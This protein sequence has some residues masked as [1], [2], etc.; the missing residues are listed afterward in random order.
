MPRRAAPEVALVEVG[1]RVD[2][3][4]NRRP[5]AVHQREERVRRGR[6]DD[7]EP[8]DV[9]QCAERPHQVAV[10]AA[11]GVA[12]TAEAVAVHRR[13][14]VVLRLGLGALELLL[15]ELDQ[16]VQVLG[17]ALLEQVVGQH[18]DQRRRQRHRHAE[19]NAIG[20]QPLE[21]LQQRQIGAGD[22][23]EEPA[24]LHDRRV[25]GVANEG[26]VRVK[27][28]REI[29]GRHQRRRSRYLAFYLSLEETAGIAGYALPSLGDV[30]GAGAGRSRGAGGAGRRARDQLLA[31]PTPPALAGPAK[32]SL[33]RTADLPLAGAAQQPLAGP[34]E[35]ALAGPP[36][37][38]FARGGEQDLAGATEADLTG[39]EEVLL[40]GPPEAVLARAQPDSLAGARHPARRPA[41][42]ARRGLAQDLDTSARHP[43]T[44]DLPAREDLARPVRADSP[45]D[46][47]PGSVDH[48]GSVAAPVHLGLAE[49]RL[50]NGLGNL[51]GIRK[52]ALLPRGDRRG[53]FPRVR[54]VG[55]VRVAFG[56]HLLPFGALVTGELVE[57]REVVPGNVAH[58]ATGRGGRRIAHGGRRS[59]RARESPRG[60][61]AHGRPRRR[62]IGLPRCRAHRQ[63]FRI[64]GRRRFVAREI[65]ASGARDLH[66]VPFVR[67]EANLDERLRRGLADLEEPLPIPALDAMVEGAVRVR[68]VEDPARGVVHAQVQPRGGGPRAK[69][70]SRARDRVVE[71]LPIDVEAV[72]V[73]GHRG[74][75]IVPVPPGNLARLVRRP[76][77]DHGRGRRSIGPLE[78]VRERGVR[79][80]AGVADAVRAGAGPG[81][82]LMRRRGRAVGRRGRRGGR[83]GLRSGLVVGLVGGRRPRFGGR[84]HGASL[85]CRRR[86]APGVRA[87]HDP[88]VI[89]RLPDP[90]RQLPLARPPE[91]GQAQSFGHVLELL[92]GQRLEA[93][94]RQGV[95][96]VPG[97]N[98]DHPRKLG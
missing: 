62:P 7:L 91:P 78:A 64:G 16:I 76:R 82:H 41:T 26:Q 55:E 44:V 49:E 79:S 52:R 22:G 84:G 47:L 40:G 43:R 18:R 20:D 23:L 37:H 14:T 97:R 83:R 27:D 24:L 73:D 10:V 17:V 96:R 5:V 32:L 80:G 12:Q 1:R 77:G 69:L 86:A 31:G 29:S 60:G 19:G 46:H 72:R 74:D 53:P 21:D 56:D 42:H 94:G 66:E 30:Y 93:R 51:D 58:L 85:R 61:G 28:Q 68:P 70:G 6:G 25:L 11:P 98:P 63:P 92:L 33:A 57:A 81:G 87:A 50:A 65:D 59:T 45:N 54:I 48:V 8:P 36:A 67:L 13:Q 71:H 4:A 89:Q 88:R 34:G 95:E 38:A 3:R 75:A 9:L 39:A 90:V 15:G 35:A 2:L